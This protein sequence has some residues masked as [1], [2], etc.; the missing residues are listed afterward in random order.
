MFFLPITGIKKKNP[1]SFSLDFLAQAH[2]GDRRPSRIEKE[3]AQTP[4]NG[5]RARVKN[6]FWQVK[7]VG[8]LHWHMLPASD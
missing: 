2:K 6:A 5:V 1:L 3:H 8:V 4:H 7:G